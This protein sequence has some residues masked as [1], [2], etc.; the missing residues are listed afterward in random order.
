MR[1][2]GYSVSNDNKDTKSSEYIVALATVSGN[3]DS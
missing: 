3:I 1:G 2:T